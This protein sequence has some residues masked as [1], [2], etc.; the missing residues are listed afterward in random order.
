[1]TTTRELLEQALEAL[2]DTREIDEPASGLM[3]RIRAHLAKSEPVPVAW[4]WVN[5]DKGLM[6]DHNEPP[7]YEEAFEIRPLYTKDQL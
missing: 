5:P 1:M 7:E 6:V 3:N 2:Y 4:E